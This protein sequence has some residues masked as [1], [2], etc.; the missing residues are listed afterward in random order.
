MEKETL[1]KY[2][3]NFGYGRWK[4]IRMESA[5]SCKILKDK[6]DHEMQSYADDFVRTLFDNLQT[7]KNEL[8]SFLI[9]LIDTPNPTNTFIECQSKDWGEVISQR[10]T[11]W[12]KRL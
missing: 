9:D 2:M 3:L 10:A 11:P 7:E 1:K 8:K 4:K 12:A 6:P 5:Q